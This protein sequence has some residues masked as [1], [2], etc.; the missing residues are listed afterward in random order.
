MQ[1]PALLIDNW[2]RPAAQVVQVPDDDG[3]EFQV[4]LDESANV[5]GDLVPEVTGRQG[6]VSRNVPSVYAPIPVPVGTE[7]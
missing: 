3:W 6:S 1:A 5:T 4:D 7:V 2:C